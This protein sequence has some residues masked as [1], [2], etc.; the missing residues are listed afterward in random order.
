MPRNTAFGFVPL[1]FSAEEVGNSKANLRV[2]TFAVNEGGEVVI[3]NMITVPP[4]KQHRFKKRQFVVSHLVVGYQHRPC[5]GPAIVRISRF[6]I[7]IFP[8][9]GIGLL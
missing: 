7:Q 9:P 6:D 4:A 8:F 3:H 5:T 2:G 1:N